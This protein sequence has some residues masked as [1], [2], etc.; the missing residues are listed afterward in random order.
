M[1]LFENVESRYS[2]FQQKIATA[3]ASSHFTVWLQKNPNA[4]YINQRATFEEF[5]EIGLDVADEICQTR[6]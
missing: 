5:L 4:P 6:T 3:W 2:E 1:K